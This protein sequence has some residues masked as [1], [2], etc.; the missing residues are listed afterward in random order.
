MPI[1]LT[2]ELKAQAL[3]VARLYQPLREPLLVGSC[4]WLGEGEDIDVVVLVEDPR[5]GRGGESCC[6]EDYTT[7]WPETRA[8]R[9][10]VVNVIAVGTR[11]EWAG[12]KHA[13]AVMPSMP[14]SLM[15][16]K[17]W[18]VTVCEELRQEVCEELR[19]AVNRERA[20]IG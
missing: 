13:A 14:K 17:D 8:Y 4:V 9:H 3:E 19:Q 6:H 16:Y 1:R 20:Y 5:V 15:Q 10:G 18:R 7:S 2:E 11:D 12:W